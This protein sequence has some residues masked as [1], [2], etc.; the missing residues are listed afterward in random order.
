MCKMY[1][2]I[3]GD[4]YRHFGLYNI[5]AGM[6]VIM[7]IAYTYDCGRFYSEFNNI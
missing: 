7:H 1:R 5:Q 2:G 4:I 6:A 3:A